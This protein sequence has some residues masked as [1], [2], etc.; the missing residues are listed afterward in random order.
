LASVLCP[1][2]S[3][4]VSKKEKKER[5]PYCPLPNRF[6]SEREMSRLSA[7]RFSVTINYRCGKLKRGRRKEE[8]KK[9]KG[10]NLY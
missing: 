2:R 1:H 6:R 10:L 8:K 5:G 9:E 4:P 3:T 7:N